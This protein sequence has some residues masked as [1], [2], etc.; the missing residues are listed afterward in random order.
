M[1]ARE[2]RLAAALERAWV[3]AAVRA[4]GPVRA[5]V[6]VL[7]LVLVLVSEPAL[8]LGMVR[9]KASAQAM[10]PVASLSLMNGVSHSLGYLLGAAMAQAFG[11]KMISAA[12]VRAL[13]RDPFEEPAVTFAALCRRVGALNLTR[14]LSPSARGAERPVSHSSTGNSGW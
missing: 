7:V 3:Q 11:R 4:A 9:G 10:V 6:L 1:Q 14:T 2:W 5:W 8:G 13:F 12:E